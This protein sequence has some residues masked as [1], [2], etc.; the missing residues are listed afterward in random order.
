LNSWIDEEEFKNVVAGAF[1]EDKCTIPNAP[2]QKGSGAS[3]GAASGAGGAA[4]SGPARI[5]G[6]IDFKGDR[7]KQHIELR[8][9]RISDGYASYFLDQTDHFMLA[10]FE[11]DLKA[12]W[13]AFWDNNLPENKSSEKDMYNDEIDYNS[14]VKTIPQS[15]WDRASVLDPIKVLAQYDLDSQNVSDRSGL[16]F[17]EF[18]YFVIF[19][20]IKSG[21]KSKCTNCF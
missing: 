10:Q 6:V 4:A 5:G 11:A 21:T 9:V 12:A 18:A 8:R 14:L 15:K 2:I 13:K 1:P 7:P 16:D 3:A 20:T 17:Q 19:E